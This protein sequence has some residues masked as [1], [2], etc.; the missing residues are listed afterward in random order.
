[1][2]SKLHHPIEPS[3][4]TA[5]G[6]LTLLVTAALALSAC[7]GPSPAGKATSAAPAQA[8][9]LATVQAMS[10]AGAGLATFDGVVEAVRQTVIAAQ[11][12]GAVVQLDAKVGDRVKAGQVLLRLDARAADQNAAAGDAQ[13]AVARAALDE[14]E[15]ELRRQRELFDKQF[16]SRAAFERAESAY[17]TTAAQVNA[18]RAQAGAARTQTGFHV[19]R[20]PYDGVVADVQVTLGDMAMPGRAL[21][22]VYDPALLRVTASVP[23]SVSSVVQAAPPAEALRVEFPQRAE[24]QRWAKPASVQVLPTVDPATHTVQWRANLSANDA[25][26]LVPGT[27]ARLTV[28][29][30]ERAVGGVAGERVLVPASTVMRRAEMHV[31]YVVDPSG[32]VSMRQ[33]R[34]GARTGEH[35][36]VLAGLA[37]DERVAVDPQAAARRTR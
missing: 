1:M 33:V 20:A 30:A 26:G 31:L 16:I 14:A 29:V 37:K 4:A 27:F 32:A 5:R 12:P 2:P 17:K 9:S 35:V 21:V 7:G 23:H 6:V 8:A 28:P 34:L 19:V 13:V 3:A 24:A 15:R 22:T 18:Q 10:A 36:E 25:Q 11:V